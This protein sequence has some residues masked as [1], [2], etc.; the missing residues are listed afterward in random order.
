MQG[1]HTQLRPA[2]SAALQ[3]DPEL[4]PLFEKAQKGGMQAVAALMD[5]QQFLQKIGEKMG[6]IPEVAAPARAG[7]AAAASAAAA[8]EVN[9]LLDAA[10]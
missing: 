1:L 6:D 3:E 8:P 10:K 4:K 2:I 9:T 7:P 5:D